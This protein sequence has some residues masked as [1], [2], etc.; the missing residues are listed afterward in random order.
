M[1]LTKLYKTLASTVGHIV[2]GMALV[3][4][5][6]Q[7]APFDEFREGFWIEFGK[8]FYEVLVEELEVVGFHIVPIEPTY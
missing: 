2:L 4:A 7:T 3:L 1:T 5:L 6:I 8:G